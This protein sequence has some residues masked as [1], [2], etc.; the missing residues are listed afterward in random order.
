MGPLEPVA[1]VAVVVWEHPPTKV[2]LVNFLNCLFVKI[3]KKF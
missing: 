1:E 2:V 3:V